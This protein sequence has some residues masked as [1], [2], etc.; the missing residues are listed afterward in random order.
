MSLR[1]AGAMCNASAKAVTASASHRREV[2]AA[3]LLQCGVP[4]NE[5]KTQA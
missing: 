5:E 1:D 3:S 4:D 2:M